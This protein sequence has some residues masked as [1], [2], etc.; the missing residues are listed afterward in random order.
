MTTDIDYATE[1]IGLKP[2]EN[3]RSTVELCEMERT[4]GYQNMSDE[5]I[6]RLIKYR[7]YCAKQDQSIA[8]KKAA[9]ESALKEL[10]D[11]ATESVKKSQEFFNQ[12]INMEPALV[13]VTGNEVD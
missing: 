11:I 10:G 13:S 3:S 6:S 9:N 4:E 12:I 2:D 5:E 7:E 1:F 8:D